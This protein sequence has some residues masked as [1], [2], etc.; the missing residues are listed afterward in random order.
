M[1]ADLA[2][3]PHALFTPPCRTPV[4][5]AAQA[6]YGERLRVQLPEQFQGEIAL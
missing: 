5:A 2:A 1:A 4:H 6:W 3:N